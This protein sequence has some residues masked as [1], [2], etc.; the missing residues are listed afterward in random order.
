V[1]V[2]HLDDSPRQL[3]ITKQ[4]IEIIDPSL[5]VEKISSPKEALKRLRARKRNSYPRGS[6]YGSSV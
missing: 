1:K 5:F 4:I 6:Q 3:N 2:L